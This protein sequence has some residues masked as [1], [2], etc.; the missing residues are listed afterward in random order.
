MYVCYYETSIH[1][2]VAVA[3]RVSFGCI[4]S[5]SSSLHRKD[6]SE[7]SGPYLALH[8][9]AELSPESCPAVRLGFTLRVAARLAYPQDAVPCDHFIGDSQGCQLTAV[10]A[11]TMAA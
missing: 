8:G 11:H 7:S 1:G 9:T 2:I 6:V 5:S 3:S 4:S 10:R